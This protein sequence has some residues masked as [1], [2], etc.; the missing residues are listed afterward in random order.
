MQFLFL[1]ASQEFPTIG[2]VVHGMA[3]K[4]YHSDNL[5][6]LVRFVDPLTLPSATGQL[7]PSF[8]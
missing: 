1:N 8:L 6:L 2:Q 4:S 5:A 3:L 7:S